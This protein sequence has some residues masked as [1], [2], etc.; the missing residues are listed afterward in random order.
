MKATSGLVVGMGIDLEIVAN[1]R[2]FGLTAAP[3]VVGFW[4][5][6]PMFELEASE[7]GTIDTPHLSDF[8]QLFFEDRR[9][10]VSFLAWPQI[11]NLESALIE[12]DTLNYLEDS[13][14]VTQIMDAD[15]LMF[16][17]DGWEDVDNIP[18]KHSE[19]MMYFDL[20]DRNEQAV[21]VF[22]DLNPPAGSTARPKRLFFMNT[23]GVTGVSLSDQCK[24]KFVYG[25]A[26]S[27]DAF[28][29][30]R[31]SGCLVD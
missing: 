15:I 29:T 26:F 18:A 13:P 5:M 8:Q 17:L 4:L 23:Q 27:E 31:H 11:D 25:S 20:L 12:V 24:A 30:W 16:F 6:S 1:L 22:F 21:T 2:S 28:E 19:L 7:T 10:K 9:E 3:L 14:L